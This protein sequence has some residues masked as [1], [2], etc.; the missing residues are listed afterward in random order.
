MSHRTPLTERDLVGQIFDHYN[1]SYF[2]LDEI[3][4][5]AKRLDRRY[6]AAAIR[7]ATRL[8]ADEGA[9]ERLATRTP[10]YGKWDLSRP[11]RLFGNDE[12]HHPGTRLASHVPLPHEDI[13]PMTGWT[14]EEGEA[15]AEE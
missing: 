2:H 14:G 8:L 9:C 1:G 4:Q 11:V 10:R 12:S 15:V 5:A 7:E 6:S 3:V 13:Y